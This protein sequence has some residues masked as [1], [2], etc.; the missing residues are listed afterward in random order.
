MNDKTIE[1]IENLQQQVQSRVLAIGAF[2]SL[3]E[4]SGGGGPA[5]KPGKPKTTKGKKFKGIK[6]EVDGNG[7]CRC[8]NLD[9]GESF[10]C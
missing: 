9:T 8:K 4:K 7:N 5:G 3:L 2:A 6:L 10:G 1:H